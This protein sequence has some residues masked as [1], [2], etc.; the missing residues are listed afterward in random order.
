M[1]GQNRGE[2]PPDTDVR[3]LFHGISRFV[4]WKNA[5]AGP[6]I[7]PKGGHKP[8]DQGKIGSFLKQ[9]R[10]EKELTQEALAEQLRVS[11]RTISRWETGSNL[12]DIGLLVEIAEFYQVSIPEIINGERKSEIMNQ[13]TKET[14]V[15]MAEYSKQET[16]SKRGQIVG[17]L[18]AGFGLFIIISALVVFPSESSWGSIYATL[19]SIVLLVGIFLASRQLFPKLWHR[20]AC[21]ALCAVLLFGVFTLTDYIA[22]KYS[23]QVPR[24][25]HMVSWSS[26][27]PDDLQ[28][29]TLFFTAVQHNPGAEDEWVEILP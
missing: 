3:F 2:T 8:M 7:A 23:H 22:V 11:S 15:K 14:A 5:G 9:L 18:L 6:I 12:P 13:E 29:K 20:F 1:D 19:G 25:C 4:S 27:N 21:V 17:A 26:E 16:R 10:K 28:Y 24:F